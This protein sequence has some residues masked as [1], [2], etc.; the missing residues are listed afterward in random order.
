[1]KHRR[2]PRPLLLPGLQPLW[3]GRRSVQLGT[4][5][6]R[7]VVLELAHPSAGRV[8]DLLD[9]SRTE[10]M[11]LDEAARLGMTEPAARTLLAD[12]TDRGLVMPAD[13]LV[14]CGLQA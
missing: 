14:P 6:R 9:G 8:L 3:R 13:A 12:L 11:V 5:P 2:H 4:D 1:M 7:A 10:R